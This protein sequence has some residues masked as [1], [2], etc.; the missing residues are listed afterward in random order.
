MLYKA[1][2]SL[3]TVRKELF[4]VAHFISFTFEVMITL[5]TSQVLVT[6]VKETA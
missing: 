5:T 4:H 6:Q 2:Y 3:I 1:S